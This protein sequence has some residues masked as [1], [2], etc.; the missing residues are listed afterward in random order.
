M[1]NNYKTVIVVVAIVMLGFLLGY[2]YAN[3]YQTK[4]IALGNG[5]NG[6]KDMVWIP[7][8]QFIMGSH[9]RLAKNNEKPAHPVQL[10][11]F[12]IDQTDVT[13][14]EFRAFVNAT[15]Y[16]TTAERKPEWETLKVQLPPG[17]AKPSEDKLVPGAMVFVGTNKAVPLDD[18][19]AWWRFVPGASWRHPEGPNSSIAGKD[20]YPVVQVSYED[21]QAYAKWA[22]KRLPTEAEW[23]YAARGGLKQADYSWGNEFKP[24]G[25]SLANTFAG[26]QFPVVDPA[27]QNKIST[28][29]V[30]SY[31]PNGYQL[32]DMAGNVWQWVADWYRADAFTEAA[33]KLA[34]NPAGPENSYDPD[35][36]YAPVNAPKRVIR[37]GS[38][39][40]DENFC[41]SYRP[42]A[43]RGVDPY[44]PMSHIS[45]RLVMT[46]Q[47]AKAYLTKHPAETTKITI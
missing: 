38:F 18:N 3:Q 34:R 2:D 15:G 10:D 30:A 40:C 28:S 4:Q 20:D 44:N 9:S 13:N 17:T 11:G 14:A 12:W 42:S 23:E 35:D 19:A 7:G 36:A 21:A 25:K 31:P 46:A 22:G 32:Y 47:M 1:K 8:N 43:R 37:G 39:L 6:P 27:Y 45:F 33:R 16:I 5:I 29:K 41:M 26:K 24:Q